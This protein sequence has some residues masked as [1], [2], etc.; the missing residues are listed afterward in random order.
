MSNRW[1]RDHTLYIAA[2]ICGAL[3]WIL[4]SALTRQTEAWDSGLYFSLGIPL[5]C[6]VSFYFGYK[7][8]VRPWRWGLLPGAG[9]FLWMIIAHGPGNLLP[10]GV[11]AF[12]ILSIPGVLAA[13]A[14][15]YIARR[16]SPPPPAPERRI[17]EPVA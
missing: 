8:P 15:G 12:G 17:K 9:Q 1:K 11:I 5:L 14:A 3:V 4:I 13:Q 7:N 2:A 6:G 16:K 10:L